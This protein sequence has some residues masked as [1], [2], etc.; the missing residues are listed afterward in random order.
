LN[1]GDKHRLGDVNCVA[2][3][4]RSY[5]SSEA[6]WVELELLIRTVILALDKPTRRPGRP[7]ETPEAP[8]SPETVYHPNFGD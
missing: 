3:R 2:V 8:S 1:P 4:K 5:R 7:L 6:R